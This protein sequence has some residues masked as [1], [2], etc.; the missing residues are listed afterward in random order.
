MTL[1]QLL[2]ILT[3]ASV[4]LDSQMFIALIATV[5]NSHCD[6]HDI[7]EEDFVLTLAQAFEMNKRIENKYGDIF[8]KDMSEIRTIL[9]EVFG[10]EQD[11]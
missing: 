2:K 9:E 7:C 6:T 8:D 10:G 5:I 3:C 11:D 4:Q 1:D